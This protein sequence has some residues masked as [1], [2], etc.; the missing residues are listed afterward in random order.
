MS[1]LND[2]LEIEKGFWTG[3]PDFYRNNVDK[4]CLLAIG[5]VAG[6][7]SGDQ[8]ASTVKNGPRWDEPA[9]HLKGFV[10]P[11]KDFVIITYEADT[12]K[13]TGEPYTAL[14]SSG[15][16]ARNGFWKLAFHQHTP[17]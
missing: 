9:I 16:V 5:P 2:L 11:R 1:R 13:P 3:G 6:A 15:Y 7:M 14:V 17:V 12:R 10:E 4:H 8:V